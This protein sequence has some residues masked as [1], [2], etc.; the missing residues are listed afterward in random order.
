MAKTPSHD[1]FSGSIGRVYRLR[2]LS[3]EFGR[4]TVEDVVLKNQMFWSS[5]SNFNDP[6]DCN[7]NLIF[8]ETREDQRVWIKRAVANQLGQLPRGERRR[9]EARMLK[10]RPEDHAQQAKGSFAR[11]M[12]ESAVCC[13]SKK[14][15]SLLMWAHY[16]D[17]HRGVNLIFSEIFDP[18]KKIAPFVAY[19]VIYS[20]E[21][22]VVD[23]TKF[24]G[25]IDA[26]KA[27]VLTKGSDWAYEEEK[28]MLEYRNPPG[29]RSFP[30]TAFK[31]VILG[32]RMSEA[33]KDW[34]LNLIG[35][36][37]RKLE[38]WQAKLSASEFKL[39]LSPIS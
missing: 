26:M 30:A 35:S 24:G 19:D 33:D 39:D 8:G 14:P 18:S 31:G 13:F 1:E 29:L 27:S 7:P 6:L 38:V 36:S 12:D 16:G 22:P 3:D 2:S 4:Q 9:A 37:R 15:D 5:P 10:A 25:N 11:F 20:D 28:R 23:V 17:C 21:R 34:L 32:A